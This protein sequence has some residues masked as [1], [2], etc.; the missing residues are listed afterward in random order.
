MTIGEKIKFHRTI[1]GL[2]QKQLGDMTGIHEVSIRKYELNKNVPKKEHLEKLAECLEVPYNEFIE[3]KIRSYSDIIPLLFAVDEAVEMN[4]VSEDNVTFRLEF[5]DELLDT[6]LR[7]WQSVK[8]MAKSGQ[9]SDSD[10]QVW[11]HMR[12]GLGGYRE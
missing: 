1:K 5:K 2:T 6:F 12:T 10:Y 7:D 8:Q 11:K 4:V 3:L 9:L